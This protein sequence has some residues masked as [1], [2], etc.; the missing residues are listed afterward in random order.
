MEVIFFDE[1]LE[2]F[3][4]TLQRPTISKVLRAIDLI[5]QFGHRLGMP[6]SKHVGE[7]L[8]EL[9]IRGPQEVRIIYTFRKNAVILLHGFLKKSR[10]IPRREIELARGKLSTLDRI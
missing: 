4:R 6:H 8:L 7:G 9:R 5:E 10:S 3:I 2:K 1:N